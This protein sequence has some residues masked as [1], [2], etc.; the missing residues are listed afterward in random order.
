MRKFAVLGLAFMA[1]LSLTVSA[2]A[3]TTTVYT[4]KTLW[5]NA[6]GGQYLTEDFSDNTLNVGVSFESTESGHINPELECY[7]D[8]LPSQSSNEPSTTWSFTPKITAYGGNWT[9]G[10]PGGVETACWF[11]LTIFA[12]DPFPMIIMVGFGASSR[13]PRSRR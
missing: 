1:L 3:L 8:V 10:G 4:D 5:A 7:Q 6:L 13:T 11:M 12:W 2:N 9:L